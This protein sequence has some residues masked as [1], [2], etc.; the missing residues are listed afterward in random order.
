METRKA[1]E[2]DIPEIRRVYDAARQYMRSNGNASQWVNG[3]PSDAH[4]AADID[5]GVCHVITDAAGSVVGAFAFIL[6]D[7][8][9]YTDIDGCWLDD[10]PYGTIHRIGSDGTSSGVMKCCLDYCFSKINNIRIDTHACNSKML[11]LMQRFGFTRCGII[12]CQD[13]TPREAFQRI[14]LHS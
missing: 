11:E 4:I 9:T 3:Y 10:S 8:P 5:N 2:A 13:G 12:I 14:I 1:T 7:D 6:G